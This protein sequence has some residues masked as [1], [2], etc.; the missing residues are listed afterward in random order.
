M[1]RPANRLINETSPYLLQHAHNPVDWYPW[2]AEAFEEAKKRN[3]PLFLS[4]GYSACHWCHVMEHESFEDPDI[5]AY[6][7][8]KFVCIKVDREER[9]DIDQIYMT[10][11]Q[12][13]TQ[14]GGWPMSVFLDHDAKPFYGGTY[15]PKTSKHGMHGF[16]EVLR[17]IRMIWDEHPEDV[18][19]SG[20][21]LQDEIQRLSTLESESSPV[22]KVAIENAVVMMLK[23]ADRR[24]GGFGTA[25]KFPHPMDVRVLMRAVKRFGN[26]DALDVVR[27]TLDKMARGGIYDHLG[28]GFARYSTDAYWLVPHFEKML[29]DNALLLSCYLEGYQLT[30]DAFYKQVSKEICEYILRDMTSPEGGFYATEDA[31]SEGV[32]GKFYVWSEAEIDELLGSEESRIFKHCYDVTA[33]GN[34]EESNILNLPKPLKESADDLLIPLDELESRL[35]CSKAYLYEARQ[36]RIHPGKDTKVLASWNGLMI[37]ALANASVVLQEPKYATAASNAARFI[38]DKMVTDEGRLLHSYKDGQARFNGYLDD[39]GC[40]IDGLVEVTLATGDPSFVESGRQLAQRTVEQFSDPDNGTFYY[41]SSDHET[42]I[43][44]QQDI[45]DNATPSG[46]SMAVTALIKLGRLLHDDSLEQAGVKALEAAGMTIKTRPYAVAQLL[47]A[48]DFLV[49]PAW[50]LIVYPGDHKDDWQRVEAALAERFLPNKLMMIAN[51]QLTNSAP[52]AAHFENRGA[53]GGEV[54]LYQ[55]ERGRC[56]APVSGADAILSTIETL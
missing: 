36:K 18:Q 26:M 12:L 43:A 35:A 1:D 37:A 22:N 20:E 46:Y 19:K 14:R 48:A 2:G 8:E 5:A 30:G 17:K 52:L 49:G 39:Y 32:E 53:A 27:L 44:R 4:V 40:L 51:D 21:D 56:L 29:Y 10:S 55:C 31:D 45:Q 11:V 23:S 24:H 42:L 6:M 16:G 28:G 15:W 54:T 13:I 38:L 41:T 34:W 33:H 3:A 9:P 7:N 25:P 50:E 47:I